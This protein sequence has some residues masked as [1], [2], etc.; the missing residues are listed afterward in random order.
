MQINLSEL[1]VQE[2]KA[3]HYQIPV[4]MNKLVCSIG[5]FSITEKKPVELTITHVKD[6]E[7]KICGNLDL[8]L[9]IPCDR[10]LEPVDVPIQLEIDQTVDANATEEE[11]LEA[12]DEQ[13]YMNGYELDVDRLICGELVVNMPVKVLCRE[14]CK[15]ICNRCGANLNNG[16]CDC[17]ITELDPRMSVIRD[18]F[19]QSKETSPSRASKK[20]K[21]K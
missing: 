20:K 10:C 2:G 12:L 9:M 5:E 6:R 7:L 17:D 15:G 8:H 1:F 13:P 18:I 14:D 16:K 4:D 11:R 19:N 3:K 21:K